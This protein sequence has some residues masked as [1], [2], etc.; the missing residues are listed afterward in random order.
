MP[1][2]TLYRIGAHPTIPPGGRDFGTSQAIF[3]LADRLRPEGHL[4]R[5]E[6]I[7]AAPSVE[8]ALFWAGVAWENSGESCEAD[9][10]P[11]W[12]LRLNG[13]LP[14]VYSAER[15]RR[16]DGEKDP[17]RQA[18]ELQVYWTSAIPLDAFLARDPDDDDSESL[19]TV[20]DGVEVLADPARVISTVKLDWADYRELEKKVF[21]ELGAELEAEITA[22]MA[23]QAAAQAV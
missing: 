11:I 12:E 16:A 5:L 7:Y 14:F 20:V 21:P 17:R 10:V 9:D 4:S 8:T 19:I 18:R 22:M 6:S 3:E 23:E 2:Y 1:D 15:W 13:P